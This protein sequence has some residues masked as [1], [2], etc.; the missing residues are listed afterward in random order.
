ML[1]ITLLLSIIAFEHSVAL[2]VDAKRTVLTSSPF[3]L[4][5]SQKMK[6][7]DTKNTVSH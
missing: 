7:G 6:V 4:M 5:K 1:W 2:V 3:Y